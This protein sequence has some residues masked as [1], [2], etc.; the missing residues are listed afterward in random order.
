MLVG[1]FFFWKRA[2]FHRSYS[3]TH[4]LASDA[5]CP[6][7]REI[8]APRPLTLGMS[9][10][11]NKRMRMGCKVVDLG[12]FC[13]EQSVW[14]EGFGGNR[15][16]P[17]KRPKKREW[18]VA[19]NTR[20]RNWSAFRTVCH[21]RRTAVELLW[22]SFFP[23][24]IASTSLNVLAVIRSL[25]VLNVT[26]IRKCCTVEKIIYL[27]CCCR[28]CSSAAPLEMMTGGC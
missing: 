3:C 10:Y 19:C 2:I 16:R 4:R 27:V 15:I 13:H 12:Q 22:A 7:C 28:C 1:S 25:A 17:K 9:Q 6:M 11:Q 14:H 8:I 5:T 18:E 21:R 26:V 24:Y 20:F 23:R